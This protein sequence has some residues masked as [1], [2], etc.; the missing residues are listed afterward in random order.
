MLFHKLVVSFLLNKQKIKKDMVLVRKQNYF[1]QDHRLVT[2]LYTKAQ[3]IHSSLFYNQIKDNSS[4]KIS[5]YFSL[6]ET[7]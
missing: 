2:N 3:L 6:N 5:Q 1:S 4:R 7:V